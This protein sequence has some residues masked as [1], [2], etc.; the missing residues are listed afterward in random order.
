MRLDKEIVLFN[1]KMILYLYFPYTDN[2]LCRGSIIN[3]C[4]MTDDK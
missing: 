2:T 1:K 4:D 3:E